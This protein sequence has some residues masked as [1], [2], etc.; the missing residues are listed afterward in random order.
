MNVKYFHTSIYKVN[1]EKIVGKDG[2][3]KANLSYSLGGRC[4]VIISSGN[5]LYEKLGGVVGTLNQTQIRIIDYRGL[6]E[7]YKKFCC[8]CF[9]D[10]N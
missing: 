2:T 7:I 1:K 4:F 5:V 9:W 3:V 6:I 10:K 8:I